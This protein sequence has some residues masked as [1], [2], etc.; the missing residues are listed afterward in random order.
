M[1]EEQILFD[2]K[3][4]N[5]NMPDSNAINSVR[6]N[7]I[8]IYLRTNLTAQGPIKNLARVHKRTY[9]KMQIMIT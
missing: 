6:F 5:K 8:L 2:E 1:I 3:T 9:N 7:S 4:L